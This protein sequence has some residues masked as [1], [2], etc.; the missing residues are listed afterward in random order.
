MAAGRQQRRCVFFEVCLV[1]T[2][3]TFC[4]SLTTEKH[5]FAFKAGEG[6]NTEQKVLALELDLAM[7]PRSSF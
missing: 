4:P 7:S 5:F 2:V 6:G 3:L 1:L